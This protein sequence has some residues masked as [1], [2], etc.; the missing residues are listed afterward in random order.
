VRIRHK[1]VGDPI[2]PE[3]ETGLDLT[4]AGDQ[5]FTL[6]YKSIGVVELL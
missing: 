4:L 1:Q 6:R 3:T 2:T 5:R